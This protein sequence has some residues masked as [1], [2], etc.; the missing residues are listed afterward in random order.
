[1]RAIPILGWVVWTFFASPPSR[2][3][4]FP[5]VPP[6]VLPPARMVWDDGQDAM[7]SRLFCTTE[8]RRQINLS[9]WWDF[10]PDPEDIGESR[11]YFRR[12]PQPETRLWVPGTW[13]AQARYWQYVG[14]AWYRRSFDLPRRGNLRLRFGGV[15]Y[16]SK[17]WLDGQ[18]LGKH[19]GGYLPF[20]FLAPNARQGR[21][22]IIVR[23][24]NR[25][26]DSTLPKRGVDWFPYGGMDR[27]VYGELVPEVWIEQFHI[28]PA[29][30]AP[31]KIN[32]QVKVFVRN[33]SSAPRTEEITLFVD[34]DELY[35]GSHKIGPPEATVTFSATL[36]QPK[37]WSPG[38]PNLHSARVILGH[39]ADDQFSRF[40]IRELRAEGPNILL[41]GRRLKLMG[42]NRHE[43]HPGWGS[44]LPPHV[45]R[46]DVEILKRLGANAVRAHYPLSE[47]FM[48]YCDQNGLVVM[49]E[50]PAWQYDPGQLA[51]EE[52]R[53]KISRYVEQMVR[54]DMNHPSI[55]SWGLG[56]EW[57]EP[58]K[59]Y[60]AIR[61]LVEHARRVDNTRFITF[62]TGGP[63]VWRVHELID[64][65]G[66]NWAQYQWYDPTTFLDRS[67]GEKSIADLNS[68]H[69]RYPN[70]PVIL[71]E[72]G[73]SESQAGWHNWGNVKWSEEYQARN[74]EDSA[75]HAL[76][77]DWI[78]G[79]CVWQF[80]DTRTA[81][82][83]ILAGRLH[84]WNAKGVLDAHRNP[85][86]AFYGLQRLFHRFE[87]NYVSGFTALPSGSA[88]MEPQGVTSAARA[89]S[90]QRRTSA[91]LR[92]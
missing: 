46:Q 72:L 6:F 78:S 60:E 36:R 91:P 68:V 65:L 20:T 24:D 32:L 88:R 89:E 18:Y 42:A 30:I 50:A 9:G 83:R 67:E 74:V 61:A 84:G 13:N 37:L 73:G 22:T 41:N 52:T 71:T 63:N 27:P 66:I 16:Y 2:G 17:V 15:F 55:L 51:N 33:S 82:E 45:I 57:R 44:A 14:P 49:S 10:V 90:G 47:M 75:R 3:E 5:E 87:D 54:R 38:E 76:E 43:D 7:A 19:E 35:S 86:L 64:V 48:D 53:S 77:Q 81:P 11:A 69:L 25:L 12:F 34:G 39:D 4:S 58:D 92:Q 29:V 21:H 70:K 80:C 85:K 79:G 26:N 28:I 56:N 8:L 1:M 40:G 23:V 31:D 62:S 59:A